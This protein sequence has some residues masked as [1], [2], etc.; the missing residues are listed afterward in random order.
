MKSYLSDPVRTLSGALLPVSVQLS[1]TPTPDHSFLI[2]ELLTADPGNFAHQQLRACTQL[3]IAMAV[4]TFP[5]RD[6]RT[7]FRSL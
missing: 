5:R 3:A 6:T 1:G 7:S 2:C 4:T